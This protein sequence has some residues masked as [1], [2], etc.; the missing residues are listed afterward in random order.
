MTIK[1]IL[2]DFGGVLARMENEAPRRELAERYRI[3]L[4]TIYSQVFDSFTAQRAALGEL[5]IE[6]HWQA[7]S[8]ALG[9]PP[10]DLPEFRQ[11]F[12]AADALD[13]EL[14]EF[15]RTLRPR[16]KVG[17]LSNAWD[18]LRQVLH[19]RWGIDDLFDE[20]IIS[21]EVGLVKPDRRIYK[22]AVSRLG[23]Q[24]SEAVFVDDMPGNVTGA[25]AAG[26]FAIQF[27]DLAQI[28][29]EMRQLTVDS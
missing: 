2:F 20:L 7:V 19:D 27:H 25:Q 29:Q 28:R 26:L 6:Q 3:P 15:I 10:E 4:E 14:V 5:T 21:A 16:Y 13:Q 1:A 11:L 23:V 24:P 18:D 8:A 22:L 12:W 17:L 9:L